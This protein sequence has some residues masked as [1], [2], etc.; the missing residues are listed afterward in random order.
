MWATEVAPTDGE[1]IN[2]AGD[3]SKTR[4]RDFNRA[5]GVKIDSKRQSP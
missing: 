1:D 2:A 3:N 4:R 5:T